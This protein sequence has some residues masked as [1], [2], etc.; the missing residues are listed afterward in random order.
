MSLE[1]LSRAYPLKE[2]SKATIEGVFSTPLKPMIF[3]GRKYITSRFSII[4]NCLYVDT[5][6]FP[7]EAFERLPTGARSVIIYRSI[8]GTYMVK[9]KYR[10]I[11]GNRLFAA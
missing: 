7:L 5:P 6:N 9:F 3:G 8:W 4:N 11:F 2:P 10:S 1:Y